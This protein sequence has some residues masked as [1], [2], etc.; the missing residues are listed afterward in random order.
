[1]PLVT[2]SCLDNI[3]NQANILDVVAPYV[4]MKRSGS[5][6]KG[7]SPFNEER[8]PSFFVHPDKQL[9]KCFSSGYAG[10]IFRFI[11]LKENLSFPES[12]EHIAHRFNITLEYEDGDPAQ[13]QQY[14]AKKHLY[15]VCELATEFF[16]QAFW[17]E[18][19]AWIRQYWSEKRGLPEELARSCRIGYAPTS[20]AELTK[21]L[22]KRFSPEVLQQSGLFFDSKGPSLKTRFNG[23]LMIP[24]RDV[25]GRV[26]AF[27]GRQ[28]DQTP[29]SD[30]T[31]KAK[32]VNSPETPIFHKSQILFGLENARKHVSNEE[33]FLLVEGQLDVLRCWSS[34]FE[35]AVAP[36]GTAIT[37][38][39]L[40]ALRRYCPKLICI[41]DGDNA[42][43]KAA[44]RL[45]DIAF[46]VGIDV[47]FVQLADGDDPDTLLKRE[48]PDALKA[49]CENALGAMEFALSCWLPNPRKASPEEK[50]E[51]LKQILALIVQ[52]ES[53]VVQDD[54][55]SQLSLKTGIAKPLI[56]SE[57]Q[58][59]LKASRQ[60]AL[61]Q[62]SEAPAV[63]EPQGNRKLTSVEYQL[64]SILLHEERLGEAISGMVDMQWLTESSTESGLLRRALAEMSEQLW[65]GSHSVEQLP[66]DD[67]ERNLIFS[68]MQEELPYENTV[69]AANT[70]IEKLYLRFLD[71]QLS[72]LD[73]NVRACASNDFEQTRTLQIQRKE[74]RELRKNV[75]RLDVQAFAD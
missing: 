39:Q 49:H 65:E 15:E 5:S 1:M 43:R 55:L 26:V 68:L 57:F 35:T 24:I 18:E 20:S 52:C 17:K 21:Q 23:R 34:G 62:S 61:F 28:T 30:P 27:A 67:A 69:S 19:N 56:L 72:E 74:L 64:L 59:T 75:P 48:G 63:A 44:E 29:A 38:T 41:L 12:I 45:L 7:L 66:Q 46:N 60:K 50:S 54:Y 16:A 32:Y 71:A 36:Q 6:W 22:T 2:R 31:Q 37:P 14:S 53:M 8:T 70:C 51:A 13:A 73:R 3:R 11:Q 25:Q 58:K 4:Q 42:G 40:I 9:F 10:D 33:P 47:S